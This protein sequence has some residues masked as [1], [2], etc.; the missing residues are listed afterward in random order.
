[1]VI[2]IVQARMGSSR[3]PGK[4]MLDICGKPVLWHIVERL[5]RSKRIDEIIIATSEN[6]ENDRIREF[7]IEESISNYSGC[8]N[9][10]L[11]RF[12]Q[13]NKIIAIGNEDSIVRITADCP[14]IDPEIID[15]VIE[16]HKDKKADYTSNVIKPSFPD[17]LDCEV[18][19]FSALTDSWINAKLKSERE[20]VTL[21][22]K[23]H[24]E[25]FHIESLENDV[26]LSSLRWTLDEPE[27]YILIKE[28]YKNLY[29]DTKGFVTAD[30]INLIDNNPALKTINSMHVR[31]EG[32]L[33]SLLEDENGN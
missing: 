16:M 7:C 33:K 12:Y 13:A 3:L 8:E 14:L 10:V 19:G 20:H 2:A 22:I 11:D 28:I 31:N 17:G 29:K 21:Y 23:N 9:D 1:M 25:L 30:I 4:V 27:D 15:R 26:N 6:I 18:M 32:L 24:P 5:K